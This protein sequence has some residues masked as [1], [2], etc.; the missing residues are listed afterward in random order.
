MFLGHENPKD[1][2]PLGALAFECKIFG[3]MVIRVEGLVAKVVGRGDVAGELV[4]DEEQ[5]SL[6]YRNVLPG[7]EKTPD[8]QNERQ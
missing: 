7:S 2:E 5:A 1:G 4:I 3:A 6:Y 8:V